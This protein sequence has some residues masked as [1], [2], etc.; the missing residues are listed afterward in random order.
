MAGTETSV[1]NLTGAQMLAGLTPYAMTDSYTNPSMGLGAADP[2]IEEAFF[3]APRYT[4]NWGFWTNL[5]EASFLYRRA[6]ERRVAGVYTDIEM[7]TEAKPDKIDRAL[8]LYRLLKPAL[9]KNSLWGRIY[10]GSAGLILISGVLT[11]RQLIRPFNINEVKKGA[12]ISI[13]S[14]DRFNGLNWGSSLV[15]EEGLGTPDYGKPSAYTFSSGHQLPGRAGTMLMNIPVHYSHVIRGTGKVTT[16]YN[17][18]RLSGWGMPYGQHV[19]NELMRDE[20]V[21]STAISLQKKALVEIV[22]MPGLNSI[23]AGLDSGG[24]GNQQQ[25]EARIQALTRWRG[26][27]NIS[28]MDIQDKYS[29]FQI[30]NFNGIVDMMDKNI[31]LVCAALEVP[32]LVLLGQTDTKGLIFTSDGAS[33]PDIEV[34]QNSLNEEQDYDARPVINKLLPI[35]WQIANGEPLPEDLT[36][37]FEPVFKESQ[38]ARLERASMITENLIRLV[39]SA[40]ITQNEARLEIKQ[41]AKSTGFGSNFK[42]LG[43]D[44]GGTGDMLL[45]SEQRNMHTQAEL[46]LGTGQSIGVSTSEADDERKVGRKEKPR[47]RN[48]GGQERDEQRRESRDNIDI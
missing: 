6:L 45:T 19:I 46:G 42:V 11:P 32:E 22:Q 3:S 12:A 25:L 21:R 10:G 17:E 36:Y 48:K 27:N 9:K 30:S 43:A 44:D 4:L 41:S 7:S 13:V 15:G 14:R 37:T 34:Y 24:A 23:A 47:G 5:F 33:S 31:R 28:F 39:K 18:T 1:N 35:I 16:L 2:I 8:E 29:Q 26:V 38:A 20:A 40:I